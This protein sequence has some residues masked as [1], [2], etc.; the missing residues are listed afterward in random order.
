[1]V[2][3]TN[4]LTYNDDQEVGLRAWRMRRHHGIGANHLDRTALRTGVF[5]HNLRNG[6]DVVSRVCKVSD[7]LVIAYE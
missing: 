1:P 6:S 5:S 3:R 7:L 2:L 4:R